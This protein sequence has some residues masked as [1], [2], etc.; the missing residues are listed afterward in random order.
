MPFTQVPFPPSVGWVMKSIL[1]SQIML[2]MCVPPLLLLQKLSHL[3]VSII[4][5]TGTTKAANPESHAQQGDSDKTTDTLDAE[6]LL[7]QHPKQRLTE[8]MQRLDF[9]ELTLVQLQNR[10]LN[11]LQITIRQCEA[12]LNRLTPEHRVRQLQNQIHFYQQQL[13]GGMSAILA[14]KHTLLANAAAKLD[15]LSPLATLKRGYAIA[16]DKNHQVIRQ[17]NDV[18]PGEALTVRV[19]HGMRDEYLESGCFPISAARGVSICPR[20]SSSDS[21]PRAAIEMPDFERET[22]SFPEGN[23]GR[24][25]CSRSPTAC[26]RWRR[27]IR[28]APAPA[29]APA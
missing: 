1:Q 29:H 21:A 28:R 23:K 12:R 8:K 11:K 15:A 2:R 3:T 10:L 26:W 24:T 19:M 6:T 18:K 13:T 25:S 14:Q 5:N 16:T 9:C 22:F 7:Q 27:R 17:A 4:A 20:T